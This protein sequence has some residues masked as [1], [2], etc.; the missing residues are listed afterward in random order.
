MQVL[1]DLV[2]R[3]LQDLPATDLLRVCYLYM[4]KVILWNT[5][6]SEEVR[7]TRRYRFADVVA[8]LTKLFD[9]TQAAA[10]GLLP[11]IREAAQ[12]V[13]LACRDVLEDV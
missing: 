3:E 1:L 2:L 11:A 10:T 7:P 13:L 6:W 12:H 5:Q 8:T 9:S 4:L